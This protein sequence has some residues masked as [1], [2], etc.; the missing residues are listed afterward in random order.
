MKVRYIGYL[1]HG[2]TFAFW[3]DEH[4]G[5]LDGARWATLDV[6][7]T[8]WIARPGLVEQFMLAD[9]PNGT[10][11]FSVDADPFEPPVRAAAA[12]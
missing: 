1:E 9:L 3:F 7:G 4:P 5:L 8:L 11:S 10:P 12:D 6:H 2:Y